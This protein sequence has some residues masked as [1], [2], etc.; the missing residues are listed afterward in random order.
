MSAKI[1]IS[2]GPDRGKVFE[3]SDELVHIGRDPGN[4]VALSD[5]SMAEVQASVVSRKGRFAISSPL[6]GVVEVEGSAIP[7]ER[8]VWLPKSAR[9][10]V[11]DQTFFQFS[12]DADIGIGE[13]ADLTETKALEVPEKARA[14]RPQKERPAADRSAVKRADKA[15]KKGREVARFIT[16]QAGDP[17]VKLGE[18]GHL[19][20]LALSEGRDRKPNEKGRQGSNPVLLYAAIAFSFCLS[21]AMLFMEAGPSASLAERKAQARREIAEYFGSGAGEPEPY[22]RLLRDARLAYSR[23]DRT[24]ERRA[25]RQVLDLLNSEDKNRLLGLTGSPEKDERLRELIAILLSTE[26]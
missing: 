22:Q 4:Q 11:S 25:Y 18:D 16:D 3:L 15:E 10:R 26:G 24:A 5:P 7:A 6:D 21:I 8:W 14:R 9:I 2:S 17:L 19:P 20:E 1:V 12:A 13:S 23:N